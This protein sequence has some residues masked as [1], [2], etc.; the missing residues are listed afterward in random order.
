LLPGAIGDFESAMSDSFEN[1]QLDCA[2]YT[3]PE[4][5][6]GMTVPEVLLSGN[7]AEIAKWRTT[8]ASERTKARRTDLLANPYWD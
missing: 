1:G 6:R 3:R 7:H 2:Y 8:N 5:Y 4:T